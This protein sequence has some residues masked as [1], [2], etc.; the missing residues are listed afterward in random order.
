MAILYE[1]RAESHDGNRKFHV[2]KVGRQDVNKVKMASDVTGVPV[3]ELGLK[4]KYSVEEV[5]EIDGHPVKL[6]KVRRRKAE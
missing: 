3:E 2:L 6:V 5:H 1:V 4:F